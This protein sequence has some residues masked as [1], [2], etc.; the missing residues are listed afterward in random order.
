MALFNDKPIQLDPAQALLV[1]VDLQERLLP[2]IDEN[3]RVVKRSLVLIQA[4]KVLGIP[5]LWT[6][7][8]KKG[9]G[10]T[11]AP[12]R[13]AI[14]D[15]ARPMEKTAFGCLSDKAIAEAAGATGR[16]QMILAG[17]EAHVC[18]MQT[19]LRALTEGWTVFLAEDAVG[20]RRPSDRETGI[21]RMTQAGCVPATTE[22]L[23]M[24]ALGCGQGERFK[25]VLPLVK[26][27]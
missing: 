24:E 1:V 3:E 27:I 11:V 19:A 12:V 13:E 17:V 21:R 22:M 8:Y 10:E 14:G 16:R 20:S 18:V 15:A 4:A 2:A 6:E 25:A 23:I 9:L 26:E 7:Q 5:I